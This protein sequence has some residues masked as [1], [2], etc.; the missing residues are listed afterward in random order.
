MKIRILSLLAAGAIAL[1]A[2]TPASALMPTPLK[3]APLVTDSAPLLVR[4]HMRKDNRIYIYNGQRYYN[5]QRGYRTYREGYRRHNGFWFPG[6]AFG[7]GIMIAPQMQN[8][9]IRSYGGNRHIEWCLNHY[10]SYRV[11]DN[12]WQPNYGQR[13]VCVS[14][15][16]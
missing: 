2:V 12:S 11:S 8:R 1:T 13:R 6:A 5:G 4:D 7:L 10:R 9:V 16:Y 14:P 3:T 15:F